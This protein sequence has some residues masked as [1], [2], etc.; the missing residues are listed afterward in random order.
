MCQ[1]PEGIAENLNSNDWKIYSEVFNDLIIDKVITPGY[2]NANPE[3]PWFR[4]HSEAR[5]NLGRLEQV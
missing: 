2:D 5:E 4:L 3:L 1:V